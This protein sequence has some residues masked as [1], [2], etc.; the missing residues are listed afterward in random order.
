MKNEINED[1]QRTIYEKKASKTEDVA[2]ESRRDSLGFK[3]CRTLKDLLFSEIVSSLTTRKRENVLDI[4]CYTGHIL[5][6]LTTDFKIKGYGV[7]LSSEAIKQAKKYKD[8]YNH[9][10]ITSGNKLPFK[11]GFF[12]GV[13]SLDVLEHITDKK[14]FLKEISRILKPKGWFIIYAVGNKY[15]FTFNW[16]LWLVSA[17]NTR[18]GDWKEAGHIEEN[19]ADSIFLKKELDYLGLKYKVIFF[20]SFFTLIFDLYFSRFFNKPLNDYLKSWKSHLFFEKVYLTFYFLVFRL[21]LL[22]FCFL[23]LPWTSLS[24]SNGFFLVGR[25]GSGKL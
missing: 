9:F 1:W 20:H 10:S 19:L 3:F 17:K 14:M 23:D 2:F 25:K 22:V 21:S 15:K 4:G 6:R 5:N 13:V 24:L 11:N 12:D 8:F 7:D 18:Y 16:F